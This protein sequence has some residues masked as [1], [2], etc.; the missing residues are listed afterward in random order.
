M[1][2]YS[3]FHI[4]F[5]LPALLIIVLGGCNAGSSP[6]EGQHPLTVAAAANMQFAMEALTESF[7]NQTGIPCELVVG[8]SGKLTAQIREDAPY[9]LFASADMKYPQS[10][11]EEGFTNGPPAI[12]AYG[13]LVLWTLEPEITPALASLGASH[14][15]HIAL[16]DPEVAPYGKAAVQVLKANGQYDTLNDRLVYGESVGQTHQFIT[17]R[18]AEVGF[19]AASLV[20]S[21]QMKGQGQWTEIDPELYEP[22]AQGVVVIGKRESTEDPAIQ[23]QQFL[24]SPEAQEILIRFGFNLPT[25]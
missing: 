15:K 10:L 12:Y 17:S 22:I 18:S 11:F 16:A 13:R 23:F 21:P 7:T 25:L 3:R 24:F 1:V 8:A 19:T 20:L 9:D 6:G 5:L 4:L 14:I 2:R